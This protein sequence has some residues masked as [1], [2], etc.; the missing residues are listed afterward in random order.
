MFIEEAEVLELLKTYPHPSLIRY[1]GCTL[2]DDFVSGI[3]LEK[4]DVILR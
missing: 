1:Y 3:V 4:L 2:R